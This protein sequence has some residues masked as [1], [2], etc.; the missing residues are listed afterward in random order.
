MTGADGP[1]P[2]VHESG[3]DFG[4]VFLV[5]FAPV[6]PQGEMKSQ[7]WRC[8]SLFLPDPDSDFSFLCSHP[9]NTDFCP[10]VQNFDPC[11]LC[12]VVFPLGERTRCDSIDL[13]L[14]L[15]RRV[16]RLSCVQRLLV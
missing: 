11:L 4:N 15:S 13:H 7:I 1:G 12:V 2:Q 5:R 6:G 3:N 14:S 16:C 8:S 9:H 10:E